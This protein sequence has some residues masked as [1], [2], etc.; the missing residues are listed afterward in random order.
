[1]YRHV[2]Q[3][4][5]ASDSLSVILYLEHIFQFFCGVLILA[6]IFSEVFSL[7]YIVIPLPPPPPQPEIEKRS[8][9]RGY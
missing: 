8:S 9:Y 4:E 3:V 5:S 2:Y 1:M 7:R 6:G